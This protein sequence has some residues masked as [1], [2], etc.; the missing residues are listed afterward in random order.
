MIIYL[1]G[2]TR[3]LDIEIELSN[4]K[5]SHRLL[6]FYYASVIEGPD[7]QVFEATKH[8]YINEGEEN[9]NR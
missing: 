8:N 4:M 7:K 1:A 3:G 5:D 9:E 6:S 2:N